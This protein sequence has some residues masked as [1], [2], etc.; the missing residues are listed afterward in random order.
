VTQVAPSPAASGIV[1]TDAPAPDH[2]ERRWRRWLDTE[3]S[4][5]WC[6]AGWIAA[7]VLFVV[8][9]TLSGGPGRI[10]AQESVYSTMAIAH[11]EFECAF[12]NVTVPGAPLIAPVYPV[13][14]GAVA[15]ATGIGH[16]VAFPSR[17]AMGPGCDRADAAVNAWALRSAAFGPTRVIGYTGWLV[18]AAGLVAWLRSAGRGRR[19]WEPVTLLAVAAFPVVWSCVGFYFHPQDLYALGFGLGAMACAQRRRWAV[20]GALI[21]L[22]VLSQQFA[23]L[24]AAPLLLLAP[25][26][27]RA[28]FVG[29]AAV[30][31]AC[32]VGPLL[33]ASAGSVFRAITLGSGNNPSVHGGTVMWLVSNHGASMVLGSRVLP[34]VLALAASWWV[35]RRLG[36]AGT[37]SASP[38]TMVALVALCLSLRLV[39]EQNLFEYYFAALAV[40]LLLLDITRGRIRGSLVAWLVTLT[41]TFSVNGYFLGVQSGRALEDVVPPVVLLA[42]LG[43]ALVTLVQKRWSHWRGFLMACVLLC[44]LVTWTQGTGHLF[45]RFSTAMLQVIFVGTGALLAATPLFESITSRPRTEALEAPP[46]FVSSL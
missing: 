27:R 40:T 42:T 18:L 31:A 8:L 25:A 32:V 19:R 30:T 12:P 10:D 28:R 9:T 20:A 33:L 16:G 3:L 14:S 44:A 37:A 13:V 38:A 26:G 36:G 22:A 24:M 23:L 17:A 5:R 21:A 39:F 11:G 45:H 29:G 1:N 41:M 6:V 2:E 4:S 34:I 35:V 46:E 15:A 43:L 7:T